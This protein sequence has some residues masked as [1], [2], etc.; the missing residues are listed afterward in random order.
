MFATLI[1]ANAVVLKVCFMFLPYSSKHCQFLSN[2][3]NKKIFK[4]ILP[5]L[6]LKIYF[7]DKI[8]SFQKNVFTKEQFKEIAKEQFRKGLIQIA[9]KYLL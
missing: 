1:M 4:R 2:K 9:S 6:N 5:N 7:R 3:N 8:K